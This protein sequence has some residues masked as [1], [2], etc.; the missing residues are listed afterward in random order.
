MTPHLN[1]LPK[2][3]TWLQLQDSMA[4][5]TGAEDLARSVLLIRGEDELY[6]LERTRAWRARHRRAMHRLGFRPRTV[7]DGAMW[8]WTPAE[9]E[10]DAEVVRVF[11]KPEPSSTPSA[12][13]VRALLAQHQLLDERAVVVLRDVFGLRTEDFRLVALI[14]DEDDEDSRHE[15]L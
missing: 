12:R 3:D 5:W 6:V 4:P 14:Y 9:A 15:A 8:E 1:F 7:R 10:L 13:Q 11:R 2:V